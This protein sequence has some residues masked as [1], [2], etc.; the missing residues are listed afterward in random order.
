[1]ELTKRTL[2]SGGWQFSQIAFRTIMQLLVLA[3]LARLLSP[4][5]FGLVAIANV[6]IGFVGGFTQFGL[7]QAIV[8]RKD[9]SSRH[10]RVGFTVAILLAAVLSFTLFA[11]APLLAEFFRN[12]S[13]TSILRALSLSF[14]FTNFGAVAEFLLIRDL[15]FN[16]IFLATV[17]AYALGYAFVGIGLAATGYGAWSL[18]GAALSTE[19]VKSVS[20]NWLRPYPKKPLLA[21]KELRELM[22]FGGGITLANLANYFANTGDY[23]VVGRWLGS[24]ALGIYQQA[25][26]VMLLPAKYLGDVLDQVLFASASRI[27]D[28]AQSLASGY[29]RAMSIINLILL[30]ISMFMMILSPEIV[31][32]M[33]GTQWDAAVLPLQIMLIGVSFRTL[34]RITGAFV[35]ARGAVYEN[36]LRASFYALLVIVGSI[37]GV[38]WGVVGVAVAVTAAVLTNYI[39]MLHLGLGQMHIGWRRHARDLLPGILMSIIVLIP[40]AIV[41]HVSRGLTSSAFIVLVTSSSVVAITLI[42]FLR[43]FPRALGNAGSWLLSTV[44]QTFPRLG[45]LLRQNPV[46]SS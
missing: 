28:Q 32:V 16:R 41:A 45:R 31:R 42:T 13:V 37:V 35:S 20:L 30:P 9:L 22:H 19:L 15:A 2:S 36:A 25:F 26:H 14:L 43:L 39:F 34:S 18:V 44:I 11:I 3:V 33:F 40:T 21:E 10:I 1:M 23:F 5:D 46:R 8:Q 38:R 24:S 27:R 7:G 4:S 29:C 12:L 6:V 17:L